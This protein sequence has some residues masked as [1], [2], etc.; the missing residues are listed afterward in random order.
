MLEV[1][2]LGRG[3]ELLAEMH[4][5][6]ESGAVPGQR[7]EH[8]KPVYAVVEYGLVVGR[9]V[10]SAPGYD[11]A[12]RRPADFRHVRLV[13]VRQCSRYSIRVPSLLQEGD[14][15]VQHQDPAAQSVGLVGQAAE[16]VDQGGER[17]HGCLL[18][19]GFWRTERPE[20]SWGGV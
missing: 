7:E 11:T 19:Q 15:R 6:R 13:V 3:A 1:M 17:S 8:C 18:G 14:I 5:D 2:S 4:A 20:P 16:V 9:D 12:G 10:G